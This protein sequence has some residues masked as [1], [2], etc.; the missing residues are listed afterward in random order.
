M[1]IKIVQWLGS[2]VGYLLYALG[3]VVLLLW[4]LFPHEAVR[5]YLEESL[6][7]VS[8]EL[9]WQVE[10]IGLDFPVGLTLRAIE[11]YGHGEKNKRLLRIDA[12][13][14]RLNWSE[15]LRARRLQFDYR[16]IAGKGSVLGFVRIDG[17]Q[18]GLHLEG[19]GQDIEL[20]DFPLLS[21]QLGRPLEGSVSG[22][23]TGAFLPAKGE[24]AELEAQL[25]VENG[26]FG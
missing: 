17:E 12:V 11:G 15:S 4:L 7:R 2:C 22:T 16:I 18:R 24:F 25:K 20:T 19:A 10:A 14:L 9:R 6:N 3:L 21:R 13:D 1:L 26:R 5:L 23:F 8:S